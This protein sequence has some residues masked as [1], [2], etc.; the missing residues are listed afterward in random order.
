MMAFTQAVHPYSR[1]FQNK[2][3]TFNEA[4]ALVCTYFLFIFSDWVPDPYARHLTG[5]FLIIIT[6]TIFGTNMFILSKQTV[7]R[8]Y[9]KC[10]RKFRER[11]HMKSLEQLKLKEASDRVQVIELVAQ[12]F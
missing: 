9:Q 11:K 8:G 5:W 3:E 2:L 6:L 4:M 12:R 1:R 10:T 7:T